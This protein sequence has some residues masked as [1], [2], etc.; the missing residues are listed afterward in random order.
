MSGV[1]K[2]QQTGADFGMFVALFDPKCRTRGFTIEQI[3]IGGSLLW[4]VID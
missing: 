2:G 4:I 3:T 1:L